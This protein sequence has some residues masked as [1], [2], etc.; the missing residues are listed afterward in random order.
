MNDKV[1]VGDHVMIAEGKRFIGE[2]GK[3]KQ[4]LPH[5]EDE[6]STLVAIALD[7]GF[8]LIRVTLPPYRLVRTNR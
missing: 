1:Q 6:S 4:I 3:I 8:T 5:P 2:T 7:D